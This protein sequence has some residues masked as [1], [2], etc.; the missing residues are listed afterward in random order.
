[1]RFVH[2]NNDDVCYQDGGNSYVR[3]YSGGAQKAW[4]QAELAAT[5]ALLAAESAAEVGAVVSTLVYD[6]GG[7][8][9]LPLG[10]Y[11]CPQPQG[12]PPVPARSSSTWKPVTCGYHS[13]LG[14]ASG[15][16]SPGCPIPAGEPA[17][18]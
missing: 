6:L 18:A 14:E 4:L 12:T 13:I 10:W 5:R 2:L 7:A 8:L 17:V 15:A 3:G 11:R 9:V 16:R 1:M